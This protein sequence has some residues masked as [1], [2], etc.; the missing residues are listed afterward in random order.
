VPAKFV[1]PNRGRTSTPDS[2]VE[3]VKAAVQQ[4]AES[5]LRPV[6]PQQLLRRLQSLY[7]H[8]YLERPRCQLDSYYRSGSHHIIYG[9]GKKSFAVL[10]QELGE[11][12]REAPWGEKNDGVGRIFL[13]QPRKSPPKQPIFTTT[14]RRCSPK[15]SAKS[16]K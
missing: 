9:L 11:D 4:I 14:G 1:A 2:L 15:R 10:K 8:G 6:S 7:H 5:S 13:E 16:L 3:T 12:F